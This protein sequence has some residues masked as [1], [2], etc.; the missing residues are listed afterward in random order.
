MNYG[1]M[2]YGIWVMVSSVVRVEIGDGD[3]GSEEEGHDAGNDD[4][5]VNCMII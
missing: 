3:W 2:G 5:L 4:G 1:F